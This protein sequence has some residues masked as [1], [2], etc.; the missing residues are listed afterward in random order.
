M[1]LL[2]RKHDKMVRDIKKKEKDDELARIT[3][4]N[5][6]LSKPTA[7]EAG[8]A[9]APRPA[10]S[11]MRAAPASVPSRPTPSAF[12]PAPTPSSA[13]TASLA[14][15]VSLKTTASPNIAPRQ[16]LL[17][18]FDESQIPASFATA[19]S[20]LAGTKRGRETD[21]T[22]KPLKA[23][24]IMLPPSGLAPTGPFKMPVT[25]N[26]ANIFGEGGKENVRR[27]AEMP[28]GGA[29]VRRTTVPTRNVFSPEP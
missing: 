11:A 4:L 26:K 1:K 29:G 24:A 23:E 10:A 27:L 17:R 22:A 28:V 3:A 9:P 14:P 12:A 16:P 19:I 5:V 8:T 13:P 18:V 25:Q 2:K 20:P 15:P 21:D 7:E 6:K